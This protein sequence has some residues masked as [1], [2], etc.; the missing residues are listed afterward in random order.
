MAAD[1]VVKEEASLLKCVKSWCIDKADLVKPEEEISPN[2]DRIVTDTL[3]LI[4][5]VRRAYVPRV[6]AYNGAAGLQ[7][8]PID[9]DVVQ[10]PGML[11][12]TTVNG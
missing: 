7:R 4:I 12:T 8:T 11:S 1:G 10:I 6:L 5:E 9:R 3:R 2:G